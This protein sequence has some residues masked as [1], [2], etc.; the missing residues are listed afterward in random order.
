MEDR[1]GFTDKKK[2]KRKIEVG[3]LCISL[4]QAFEFRG[5]RDGRLFALPTAETSLGGE[6]CFRV[7]GLPAKLPEELLTLAGSTKCIS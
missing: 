6:K 3:I 1:N 4:R 5:L 7:L 2:E